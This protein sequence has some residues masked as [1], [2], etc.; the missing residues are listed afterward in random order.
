MTNV[1]R[2]VLI[3]YAEDGIT[4]VRAKYGF[5][6]NSEPEYSVEWRD[7][8]GMNEDQIKRLTT[9]QFQALKRA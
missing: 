1:E 7:V 8:S 4:P 5:V 6:V 2:V 3:S 9:A